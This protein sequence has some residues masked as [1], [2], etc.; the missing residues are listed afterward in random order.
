MQGQAN[1][2]A[3]D[4]GHA[5]PDPYPLDIDERLESHFFIPWHHRRWLNSEMRLKGTP[6]CRALYFDLICLSQDQSPVGT[7]PN[8]REQL[9]KLLGV[10][11]SHFKELCEMSYGPLY[12]WEAC[13]CGDRVRLTHPTVREVVLE[14][15]SRKADNRARNEAGA[16]KK[17]LQRLR[18]MVTGFHAQLG[19]NDAAISWMDG[20]LEDRDC[21]YRTA[22]WVGR[23]MQAWSDHAFDLRGLARAEGF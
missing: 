20:W 6:E 3:L 2:I 15:V 11:E 10:A 8:D 23:A 14:A 13:V 18:S 7:L 12:N 4:G 5:A 1:L 19:G 22:D 17:R 9:A 16:R 21:R